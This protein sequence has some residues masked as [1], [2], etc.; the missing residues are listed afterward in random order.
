[1]VY[2]IR[3]ARTI[4]LSSATMALGF[5]GATCVIGIL[6]ALIASAATT[7]LM[8]VGIICLISA[9]HELTDYWPVLWQILEWVALFS[10]LG[11]FAGEMIVSRCIVL[12][13]PA[14]CEPNTTE[15]K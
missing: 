10:L 2:L 8:F 7:A 14:A 3:L 11:A 13:F 12:L 4:I 15:T 9:I 1:M 6:R 5:L